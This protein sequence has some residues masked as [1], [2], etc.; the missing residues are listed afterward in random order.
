MNSGWIDRNGTKRNTYGNTGDGEIIQLDKIIVDKLFPNNKRIN[1]VNLQKVGGDWECFDTAGKKSIIDV[2]GDHYPNS[3]NIILELMDGYNHSWTQTTGNKHITDYLLYIRYFANLNYCNFDLI[4]F[5]Y[6]T[7]I[8]LYTPE[9]RDRVVYKMGDKTFGCY[10]RNTEFP[11]ETKYY[12][13]LGIN[14]KPRIRA[15][16]I[17][18]DNIPDNIKTVIDSSS[19]N[20]YTMADWKKYFNYSQFD[21]PNDKNEVK[22]VLGPYAC[23]KFEADTIRKKM[24]KDF[25][26]IFRNL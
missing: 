21:N 18:R 23:T 16:K 15:G 3:E 2:K 24:I 8:F 10:F 13:E 6:I 9:Y 4:D 7:N 22:E 17:Y 12:P 20:K 5:N 1:N 26:K 11:S 19:K 14:I 25:E